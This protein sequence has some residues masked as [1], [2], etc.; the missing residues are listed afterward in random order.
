MA[1]ASPRPIAPGYAIVEGY[2]VTRVTRVMILAPR[3][4]GSP[5]VAVSVD[6]GAPGG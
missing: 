3:G 6:R 1:T 4:L 2:A 5:G